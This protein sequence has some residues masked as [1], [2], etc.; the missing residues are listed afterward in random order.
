MQSN[1]HLYINGI[2]SNKTALCIIICFKIPYTYIWQRPFCIR[3]EKVVKV[4][5]HGNFFN[6]DNIKYIILYYVES[7]SS[8]LDITYVL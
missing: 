6:V 2:Y 1:N 3:F 5:Y 4:G 7:H 8:I